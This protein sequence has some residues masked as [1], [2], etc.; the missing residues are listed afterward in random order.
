MT[1]FPPL[2]V[3]CF[4]SFLEAHGGRMKADDQPVVHV[5]KVNLFDLPD[6]LPDKEWFES[7]IPDCGV[8]IE[9]II[10]T[11]QVT[12]P[13]EWYDQERD[14]WVVLLQGEA[15][16][17]WEYG[18]VLDL[19]AGDA[20]LIPARERHRVEKTSVHPPCIWLAVH[21]RLMK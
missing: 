7:L 20:I 4:G 14:E 10:S 21:G 13:G 6:T 2:M 16:L 8:L 18:R 15:T 12:P 9:R 19:V 11:G 1:G 5:K 3:P 17:S